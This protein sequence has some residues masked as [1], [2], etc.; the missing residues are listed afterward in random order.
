[1]HLEKW[2]NIKDDFAKDD[3]TC[4]LLM[5]NGAS[6][7][8]HQ[9]LSYSS[10]YKQACE[11]ELLNSK[12][13]NLFKY[14]HT[15]N[16]EILLKLL[17]HAKLINESLKIKEDET[18]KAY[19]EIKQALV[20]TVVSVHPTHDLIKCYLSPM[21]DFMKPFKRVFSLNY[22]L[23]VYWAMLTGNDKY[24]LWFKDGFTQENGSFDL[25][26]QRLFKPYANVKGSTFVFY[27]HGSLF[28]ATDLFGN[29]VKVCNSNSSYLIEAILDRWGDGSNK[30][31]RIPLF[32]S[33]GSSPEKLMRIKR[34]SYLNRIYENEL[35]N[36]EETL[37]IYGWSFDKQDKH[38][39]DSLTKK[40]LDSIAISVHK[41]KEWES[42]CNEIQQKLKKYKSL[43]NC[44]LKFFDA[45]SNDC[46][47]H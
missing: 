16:F 6:I 22:D 17:L 42:K 44:K 32:V 18:A 43:K 8:I 31:D 20:K 21:A 41:G 13:Q 2:I 26:Y 38:I 27:P 1:M 45:E 28:L 3:G 37:V 7:A 30:N 39:L 23:L 35:S 9:E 46:W 29:E 4:D 11:S 15:D 33:E 25:D 24:G 12:I 34:S 14:F 5:G 19:Q 10:L 40:N 47:I 36:L